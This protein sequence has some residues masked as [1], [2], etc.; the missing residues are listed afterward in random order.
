ME[1]AKEFDI[2]SKLN[3][4]HHWE[5]LADLNFQTQRET[6]GMHKWQ[7]IDEKETKEQ[8]YRYDIKMKFYI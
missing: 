4:H 7:N 6:H 5:E 2:F 8:Y 1:S 3:N